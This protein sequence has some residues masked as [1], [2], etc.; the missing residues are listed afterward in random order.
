LLLCVAGLYA[1]LKI[2]LPAEEPHRVFGDLVIAVVLGVWAA[3]LFVEV[4]RSQPQDSTKTRALLAYRRLLNRPGTLATADLVLLAL[5][6][7]GISLLVLFRPVEF[8]SVFNVEV[9]QSDPGSKPFKLGSL[10]AAEASKLRIHTGDRW[11]VFY[12]IDT[13]DRGVALKPVYSTRLHVGPPWTE[14][15]RVNVPEVIFYDGLK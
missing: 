7:G 2:I 6:A 15:N 4:L 10:K 8:Y 1:A 12:A 11:L 3:L 9:Y 13:R 5:C 14:M